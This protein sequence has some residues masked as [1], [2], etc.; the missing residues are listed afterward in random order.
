M[1]LPNDRLVSAL[2]FDHPDVARQELS[3]GVDPNGTVSKSS[4][5]PEREPLLFLASRVTAAPD[6]VRLLLSYGADPH[7]RNDAGDTLLIDLSSSGA[8]HL[9]RV[10]VARVLLEAGAD[11]NATDYSGN[12]ALDRAVEMTRVLLGHP[13]GDRNPASRD[14]VVS[15][16]LIELLEHNGGKMQRASRV[17]LEEIRAIADRESRVVPGPRMR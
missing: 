16:Y 12:T 10:E 11:V 1:T 8:Q 7:A 3:L 14:L 15:R 13:R 17:K 6:A 4:A 5:S 9:D 2:V